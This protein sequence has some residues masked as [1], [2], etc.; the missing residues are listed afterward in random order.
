MIIISCVEE[1]FSKDLLHPE[2]AEVTMNRRNNCKLQCTMPIMTLAVYTFIIICQ[3]VDFHLCFHIFI[4]T[5]HSYKLSKKI[6][7]VMSHG[8]DSARV[9]Y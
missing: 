5:D 2:Q 9:S 8:G 7:V 1:D 3:S 4:S 6:I